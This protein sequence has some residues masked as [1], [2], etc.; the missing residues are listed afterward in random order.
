M[1]QQVVQATCPGCK[2]VLRLPA[3]WAGRAVRCKGCGASMQARQ[4]APAVPPPP[5]S[6]SRPT[7]P[8]PPPA[9]PV[10]PPPP[11]GGKTPPP[12][13][14]PPAAITAL[15]PVPPPVAAPVATPVTP[16]QKPGQA[17]AFDDQDTIS[18]G[19]TRPIRK[20]RPQ[21]S[22]MGTWITL[23][24]LLLLLAGGG[25]AVALNW[26][27]IKAFASAKP[28]EGDGSKPAKEKKEKTKGKSGV[29]TAGFPRRALVISVHNYLY[30]NPITAGSPGTN[31]T[32]RLV[33]SLNRGLNIPLT[34]IIE[35]SDHHV[36]T[37][38]PPLKAVIEE[39][40][41]NFLKTTRKQDRV[42]ILFAGHTAEIEGKA[43]LIPVE[44]EREA[45]D[46]LIPLTWVLDAMAKTE[47]RQ[48]L[49]ILDGHRSNN[50]QGQERPTSGE[51]TEAFEKAIS[52]PPAGVQ[53][54]ASCS[55]GQVSN[56][57]D[58]APLGLFLDNFRQALTPDPGDKGA[59]EGRIQKPEDPIPAEVFRDAVNKRIDNDGHKVKQA[60]AVY[61][62]EPASGADYDKDEKAAER[63]ALP[64]VSGANA[65]EIAELLAEI[66]LPSLKGAE[67]AAADLSAGSL[68]PFPADVMK[69][70]GGSLPLDHPLRA[71][72]QKARATLWAISRST[73]PADLAKDVG[74]VRAKLR[75]D[76]SIMRERYTK[77]AGGGMAENQFKA[78]FLDQSKEVS[79]IVARLEEDLEELKEAGKMK[80]DA[81]ARW[82]ANYDYILARFQAQLA[83]LEEYN[84]LLG[85]MRKELPPIEAIHQGW[86]VSSKEKAGDPA[87][88]K[89]DR[90]A[91]TLYGKIAEGNAKTPW[92]VI[93]KREKLT[94][95]GLEWAAY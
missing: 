2:S 49:F 69:K 61:G 31:D 95:L 25:I 6:P 30:M 19:P 35:L 16:R 66:S 23:G 82:Q 58:D 84:S 71:A 14:A 34:Q 72:V 64:A 8:P 87:G 15:P 80:D 85:S 78:R 47:C 17:F 38:R 28:G 43:Y 20:P 67:G 76:L 3:E 73:V 86:R 11:A 33:S 91:R 83:Y 89:Y 41:T 88:K 75:V 13:P 12:P 59:L 79:R 93:A 29:G 55:K 63:P 21:G 54:W 1:S 92:E 32:S 44:G 56:E 46:T 27:R 52:A 53:V 48:K 57:F 74:A 90:A 70:Y 45:A 22:G 40:V 51:M 62:K 26:E 94:A 24:V 5:P 18:E 77:P 81:P 7:P 9:R 60:S 4:T 68:P 65:R 36:K 37:P 10:P 39:M 42:I 50:A